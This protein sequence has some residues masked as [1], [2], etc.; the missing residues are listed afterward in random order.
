MPATEVADRGEVLV[1]GLAI[2]IISNLVCLLTQALDSKRLA[3]PS[4]VRAEQNRNRT[5]RREHQESIL[6]RLALLEVSLRLPSSLWDVLQNYQY[7]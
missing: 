3:L 6:L 1:D 5:S 4:K 2:T 7:F